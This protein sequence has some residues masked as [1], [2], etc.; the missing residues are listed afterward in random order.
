MAS[1]PHFTDEEAEALRERVT[2]PGFG[3]KQPD[4][5]QTQ[6]HASAAKLTDNAVLSKAKCTQSEEVL[7]PLTVYSLLSV[8]AGSVNMLFLSLCDS[9]SKQNSHCPLNVLRWQNRTLAG[10]A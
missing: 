1:F 3:P 9:D 10:L 8:G 7:S 5:N 4:S 6:G 2:W